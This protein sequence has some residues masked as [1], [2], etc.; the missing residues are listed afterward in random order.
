MTRKKFENISHSS[1]PEWKKISGFFFSL[2]EFCELALDVWLVVLESG[3]E[4]MQD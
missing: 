2:F 3:I 4:L 1:K